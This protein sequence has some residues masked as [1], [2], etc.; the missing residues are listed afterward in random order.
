[1]KQ[2]GPWQGRTVFVATAANG[3][4]MRDAMSHAEI[5]TLDA[6]AAATEAIVSFAYAL[7]YD[8]LPEEVR[9]YA[10]R[11][12][13]DTIGVMI[14]GAEGDAYLM[15]LALHFRAIRLEHF[16]DAVRR[17]PALAQSAAKLHVTSPAEIDRLYPQLRPAR[18]TVTTGRGVFER[19][20]DEALGS[21]L[22]PLDDY[23]LEQKFRALVDPVLGAHRARALTERLWSLEQLENVRALV[24]ATTKPAKHEASPS[25]HSVP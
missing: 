5:L 1:M 18:V 8:A 21:R 13:L 19:Q 3:I 22:V 14:A 4:M 11:H 25:R 2:I 24:E 10:R 12:L 23:G 7:R 9:H 15:A 6:A 17:D 20:A 16:A